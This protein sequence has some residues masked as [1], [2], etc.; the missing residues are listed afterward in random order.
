M[1]K[2]KK[3]DK[4]RIHYTGTLDD[5]TQFDS[6]AGS[7]PL[8]FELGANQVIPGFEAAIMGMSPGD[9]DKI[10]IEAEQA[11]GPRR[12]EMV[13]TAPRDQIPPGL[14]PQV[15][16]QLQLQHPSGEDVAVVVTE[17]TDESV[18][19]DGNHPLSGQAL[20]FELELVEI[21]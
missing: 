2:A 11:Y 16:Q 5:G 21:L 14:D 4:V 1:S 10:R 20:S 3:G 15:G 9:T 6:S 7:D 12:E 13:L 18:T 17:V 8:E 19:L